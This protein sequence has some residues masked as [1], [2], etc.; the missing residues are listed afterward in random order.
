MV[1]SCVEEKIPTFLQYLNKSSVRTWF[2][3]AANLRCLLIDRKTRV[4]IAYLKQK[5][6][7]FL[8]LSFS[9]LYRWSSALTFNS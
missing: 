8:Y 4:Y 2:L 9:M 3:F 1:S 7:Y 6:F 5:Y